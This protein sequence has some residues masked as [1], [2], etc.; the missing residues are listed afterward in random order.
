V[1]RRTLI[2]G[3]EIENPVTSYAARY[4]GRRSPVVG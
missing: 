3:R 1:N 2:V 4:V